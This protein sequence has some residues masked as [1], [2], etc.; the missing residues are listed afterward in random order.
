[1]TPGVKGFLG[2]IQVLDGSVLRIW[3][4]VYVFANG[5][6]INKSKKEN[7]EL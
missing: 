3:V 7:E 5:K 4:R 2:L 1:M 6:L